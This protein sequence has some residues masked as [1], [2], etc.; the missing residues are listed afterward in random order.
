MLT[1]R[2]KRFAEIARERN[3][4]LPNSKPAGVVKTK[5][6]PKSVTKPK[7]A[8]STTPAPAALPSK[9]TPKSTTPNDFN[10]FAS[11]SSQSS[12]HKRAPPTKKTFTN[13]SEWRT[14]EDYCP[15]VSSLDDAE[16]PLKVG[17]GKSATMD[18][19]SDADYSELHATE[20][21]VAS[22]LRLHPVQYLANK[23][24]IFNE[25]VK[26]LQAGQGFTKTAAQNVCNID[27]NK[28][29]KLW[30]AFAKV[31]WFDDHWFQQYL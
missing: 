27:V 8:K 9:R 23:R 18:I 13:D 1:T 4:A 24:R 22:E 20:A 19:T 25:K 5:P 7:A 29:S 31:G 30:E 3:A 14:F 16:K 15:P 6:S 21:T 28:V 10:D 26:K 12:K 11:P 17:W 2:Q